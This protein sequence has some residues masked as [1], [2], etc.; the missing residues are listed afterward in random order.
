M[1]NKRW[2]M[3][4]GILATS[5]SGDPEHGPCAVGQYEVAPPT[6]TSDRV[7]ADLTVCLE[8]EY[9]S[10]APTGTSDRACTV[11][12]TCTVDE[13]E[14]TA[15]TGTSDRSCT[16]LTVCTDDEYISTPATATA[17]RECSNITE[18]TET[19]FES[20][21]PTE[22]SDREC[23]DITE[24]SETEFESSPPTE[25]SD[26]ECTA[27]PL[28]DPGQFLYID[29]VSPA[30]SVCESCDLWEYCPGHYEPAES[31]AYPSAARG[32][33]GL[34][35]VQVV[36]VASGGAHSCSLDD[37]GHV[38]C[39][40][41]NTGGQLDVPSSLGDVVDI[42]AG[43][44]AFYTCAV[45][46]SGH[47]ACWGTYGAIGPPVEAGPEEALTGV[48]QLAVSW[49]HACA[50]HDAGVTC[51]GPG[52]AGQA[53]VP[54]GLGAVEQL[55]AGVSHTCTLTEAGE[56]ICWGDTEVPADLGAVDRIAAFAFT[57]CAVRASGELVCWGD[58]S[59]PG[60]DD[61]EDPDNPHLGL[62]W[63]DVTGGLDHMCA[64][65]TE[66]SVSCW[67]NDG[68]YQDAT[69]EGLSGVV[70][71]DGGARHTCA[72]DGAGAVVCWGSFDRAVPVTSDGQNN[73]PVSLGAVA[74]V[75]AGVDHTCAVTV[76][77]KLRCWGNN[78]PLN[79]AMVPDYVNDGTVSF[80]LGTGS[81]EDWEIK[82]QAFPTS[83]PPGEGLGPEDPTPVDVSAV[84][85]STCVTYGSG[86]ITCWGDGGPFVG[87]EATSLAPGTFA[88]AYVSVKNALTGSFA[89][90]LHAHCLSVS[91]A[92][93]AAFEV[94]AMVCTDLALDAFPSYTLF[95]PFASGGV[96]GG[97]DGWHYCGLDEHGDL[98]CHGNDSHGQRTVPEAFIGADGPAA[99]AVAL[100][101]LHTC[102]ADPDGAVTCWGDGTD[103][104]T[105]VPS[106]LDDVQLLA[107]GLDHTCA[108]DGLGDVTCW[109]DN[110]FGQL[111]VP[112]SVGDIVKIDAGHHHTCAV[113]SVGALF[114]WGR[115]DFG[116]TAVWQ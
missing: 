98:L 48:R 50:L 17:D 22:T 69:P 41:K 78:S 109:G 72:I 34:P 11:L 53:V 37:Y 14:D 67:G 113:D 32:D 73:P 46:S 103:G 114:C 82:K 2:V 88:S 45:D 27:Y 105:T 44:T 93:D 86:E 74:T 33:A 26:R 75:S 21:P 10:T 51:W 101:E 5:C 36:E 77:G 49:G 106:T 58:Q 81:P 1:L 13:Y 20:S 39:W 54:D 29:E 65:D 91:S 30:D 25:T 55:V 42:A 64:L 18:C 40:G 104:K 89:P 60:V 70:Q 102:A 115:N 79:K 107:G 116:Q 71:L 80:G 68:N 9:E 7:C 83:G 31:C 95:S 111:D 4:A 92:D 76:Q 56:V 62:S 59:P 23:S 6:D 16:A 15:P 8:D 19:E 38:L 90:S 85:R 100:G 84:G 66:G 52:G 47:I 12:T 43:A 99:I 28:C 35:C 108:V 24:C 61:P 57:T 97:P 96:P 63:V 94:D 87:T 110:T 3:L 112:S